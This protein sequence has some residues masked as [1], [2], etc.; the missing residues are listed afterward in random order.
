M[1]YGVNWGRDGV[2]NYYGDIL[3]RRIWGGEWEDLFV[4][5]VDFRIDV[6]GFDGETMEQGRRRRAD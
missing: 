6:V 5:V 2:W 3:T 4:L 1:P